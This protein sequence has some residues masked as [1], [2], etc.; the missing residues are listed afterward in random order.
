[1]KTKPVSLLLAALAAASLA[2]ASPLAAAPSAPGEAPA[3]E[4]RPKRPDRGDRLE[5]MREHLDL[6]DE[7]VAQLKPILEAQR[8]EM[9][10]AMQDLGKDATREERREAMREVHELY[11]ERIAAVLTAEQ[12]AKLG[13]MRKKAAKRKGGPDAAE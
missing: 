3:G 6:T 10:A 12:K 4:S 11:R 1:M 9:K 13:E 8:E 2:L 7:Q 5:H